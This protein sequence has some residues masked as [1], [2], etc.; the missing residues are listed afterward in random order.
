MKSLSAIFIAF[1]LVF[2]VRADWV[3]TDYNEMSANYIHPLGNSQD[4]VIAVHSA[5]AFHDCDWNEVGNINSSIVGEQFFNTLIS[6][7]L[8]AWI[9]NKKVSLLIDGCDSDRDKVLG[10]R[11]S[12]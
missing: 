12:K 1:V 5:Q 9:A 8:A 2:P 7:S 11:I 6:A 3:W 10:M 4:R